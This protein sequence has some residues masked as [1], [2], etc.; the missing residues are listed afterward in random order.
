MRA[1]VLADVGTLAL[2]ERPAPQVRRPDDVLLDVEACGICGTDLH[3]LSRPP[4]HPAAVGVVLGHEI[5]GVVREVGDE[6]A[7]VRPGDRVVVTPNLACG[8]CD[9]CRRGLPN[10]CERFTTYGV[11][12]DGGLASAVVV[13]SRACH[14]IAPHVPA[15]LAALAEPL[16]T[17]VHGARLAAAA[18]GETAVVLGAGPVGLMF[19]ALLALAGAT[20]TV[21]EPGE[22]RAALAVRMGAARVAAP[23]Q[24]DGGADI[25]VDAVGTQL[26]AAL[27][28][29]RKA[30][31]IVLF[32]LDEGAR[33]EISQ[34]RITRNEL[35]ILGAYVG[36]DVMRGA[37]YL[38]EEGRLD[39]EP[40]VTQRIRLEE[41]PEAVE[42][43][44]RGRAAKVV[45]EFGGG[46]P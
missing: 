10:H 13:A 17:V 23:G 36:R 12:V 22:Q 30:G 7:S 40:L 43:L 11:F 45:V 5:A 8:E 4:G 15:H 1:A 28:L 32:G 19:T 26:P 29:V 3:I 41:L 21:V 27:D 14:P 6:V 9:W 42:E 35:T 24:A 34:A 18:P 39:L 38:L 16:S 44:R 31:R 20:V 25:V 2:E 37:V 46:T 33:A